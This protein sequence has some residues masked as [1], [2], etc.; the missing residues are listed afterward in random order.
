MTYWK[1]RN[2]DNF[3]FSL[4]YWLEFV[5]ERLS[6]SVIPSILWRDQIGSSERWNFDTEYLGSWQDSDNKLSDTGWAMKKCPT[7]FLKVAR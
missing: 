7:E 1:N 2:S 4:F 3:T 5:V 6:D